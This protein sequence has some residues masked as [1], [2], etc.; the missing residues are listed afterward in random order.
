MTPPSGKEETP[1][2]QAAQPLA[3]NLALLALRDPTLLESIYQK[4][5]WTVRNRNRP[6]EEKSGHDQEVTDGGDG[7]VPAQTHLEPKAG[8]LAT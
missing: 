1:S 6:P 5:N 2:S 3:H 7:E 8:R 4:G